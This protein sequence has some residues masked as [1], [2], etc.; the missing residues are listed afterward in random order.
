MGLRKQ[1]LA[2]FMIKTI[3]LGSKI[4]IVRKDNEI[5]PN[6]ILG[7]ILVRLLQQTWIMKDEDKNDK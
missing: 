2:L 4:Y 6:S 1:G 3:D 7:F 5:N